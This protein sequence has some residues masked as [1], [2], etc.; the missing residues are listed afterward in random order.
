MLARR[1]NV[2]WLARRASE[3]KLT[4]RPDGLGNPSYAQ[5]RRALTLLEMILAIT[6]AVILLA[7]VYAA[8]SSQFRLAQ[9][10]RDVIEQ[11]TLARALLASMSN[12]I[13]QSLGPLDIYNSQTSTSPSSTPSATSSSQSSTSASGSGVVFNQGL[14]GNTTQVTIY[15]SRIPRE[16]T[17]AT[18]TSAADGSQ[19]PIVSDLRSITYWLAGGTGVPLGLA[20]KEIKLATANDDSTLLP[21][22][23]TDE[24]PYIIAEEVRDLAFRYFDGANW[25]DSWDGTATQTPDGT[26]QIGPIGPP[27]AIEITLKVAPPGVKAEASDEQTWKTYRHVVFLPTANGVAQQGATQ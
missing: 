27:V 22:D 7:A 1:A 23:I 21:P 6:I 9:S 20:R 4:A 5:A 17:Y 10:G 2:I 11:S 16:L 8:M 24:T 26:Q 12:D 19:L 13:K 25:Q 15:V 3:G 14:Q 18:L